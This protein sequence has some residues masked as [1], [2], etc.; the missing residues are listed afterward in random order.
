MGKVARE[1]QAEVAPRDLPQRAGDPADGSTITR[2]TKDRQVII[3]NVSSSALAA[4]PAMAMDEN[5]RIA[6]TIHSAARPGRAC[7][8]ATA[9]P[10]AVSSVIFG[11]YRASR[12][13]PII[14][15]MPWDV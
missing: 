3:S 15:C 2:P 6:P 11:F 8:S 10:L 5:D 13:H 1:M 7:T 14:G 12:Q 4:R 9:D